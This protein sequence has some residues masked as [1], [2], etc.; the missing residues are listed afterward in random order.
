MLTTVRCPPSLQ[1]IK[2]VE[3]EGPPFEADDA[4]VFDAMIRL[5]LNASRDAVPVVFQVSGQRGEKGLTEVVFPGGPSM[6]FF[7]MPRLTRL[8]LLRRCFTLFCVCLPVA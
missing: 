4:T 8:S 2:S 3:G 7:F 1:V 5:V 6:L